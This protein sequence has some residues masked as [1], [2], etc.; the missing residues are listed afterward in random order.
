MTRL[1]L[2]LTL[3]IAGFLTF[4]GVAQASVVWTF[5]LPATSSWGNYPSYPTVATLTLTQ[6]G[7]GVKFF[8][9][10]NE[11][12][13]GVA[14]TSRGVLE[15]QKSFVNEIEYVYQ[16]RPLSGTSTVRRVLTHGDFSFATSP[17]TA[18]VTFINGFTYETNPNMDAGYKSADQYIQV[19]FGTSGANQFSF[20]ETRTWTIANVNLADFT[21]TYA[22]TNSGKPTPI[23]G[24]ISVSPYR[25]RSEG[26]ST[27]NWVAGAQV[28]VIPEP[29]TYAMLLAG[30]GLLG[31]AAR[32]RK[33]S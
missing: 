6:V 32:R 9:D 16:G 27:S 31:F 21:G 14:Q 26:I 11:L 19:A 30:L 10:P 15:P 7:T 12:S 28:S 1:K 3:A 22:T 33:N 4:S 24:V 8:L 2:F 13:P 5:N 23:Y 18:A 25:L 20:N 17:S 29:E